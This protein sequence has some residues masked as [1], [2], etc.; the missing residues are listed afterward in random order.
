M[1][2]IRWEWEGRDILKKEEHEEEDEESLFQQE[3]G[4]ARMTVEAKALMPLT[5][6]LLGERGWDHLRK[7]FLLLHVL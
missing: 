7:M 5:P 1:L 6:A 2:L 3:D 4:V